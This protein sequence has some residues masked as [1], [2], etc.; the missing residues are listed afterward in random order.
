MVAISELLI[1]LATAL[2]VEAS[3]KCCAADKCFA[4]AKLPAK[5]TPIVSAFCQKYIHKTPGTVT[6]TVSATKGSTVSPT[7]VVVTQPGNPITIRTTP[8]VTSV[9]TVT[10]TQQQVIS[11]GACGTTVT[12]PYPT[13]TNYRVRGIDPGSPNQRRHVPVIPDFLTSN[14]NPKD[15]PAKVSKACSCFLTSATTTVTATQNVGTTLPASTQVVTAPGTTVLETASEL[16]SIITVTQTAVQT[17]TTCTGASTTATEYTG[18]FSCGVPSPTAG[19]IG[20]PTCANDNV[21]PGETNSPFRVEGASE[22]N[23]FDGCIV[24]GPR[25]ITTPSGG[26]HLCDGTNNNAN[27]APGA[28]F[29]TDIQSAGNQAGFDLDGSYSNQFQDFFI[30]RISATAQTGNQFWGVLRNRVFTARG[31]CQEQVSPA[32]EALWAYD[33]FAPNR[34]FLSTS[35]GY[36]VVRLGDQQSITVTVLAGNP[37]SGNTIPAQGATFGTGTVAGSDGSI[38]LTVPSQPGCYLYKAELSNAIRSNAF[39]LSVLPASS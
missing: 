21:P 4:S 1:V 17:Q 19:Q 24:S 12:S 27:P 39:Y 3:S 5:A 29:T 25:N 20:T 30:T 28:T 8:I 14:C 7:P 26:T 38:Q 31:G 23:I 35:P 13:S 16:S 36:Q 11:S 9:L 10:E 37:N 32:D 18:V 34:V 6:V 2:S 22:G 33:A 15:L